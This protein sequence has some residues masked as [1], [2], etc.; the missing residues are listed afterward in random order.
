MSD[1]EGEV[2]GEHRG[3]PKKNRLSTID[4][5]SVIAARLGEETRW[6]KIG[7]WETD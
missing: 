7:K 1:L 5:P 2:R 6:K 4:T 3:E